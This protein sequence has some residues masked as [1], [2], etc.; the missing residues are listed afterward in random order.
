MDFS[1]EINLFEMKKIITSA[2]VILATATGFSQEV[3]WGVKIGLNN[4]NMRIIRETNEKN[5]DVD[6]KTNS[7][8]SFYVGGL[9]EVPIAE[10]FY[11]QMELQYVINGGKLSDNNQEELDALIDSFRFH[12]LNI[13]ILAKYEIIEGFKL[14]GGGYLGFNL[15]GQVKE[16]RND[17]WINIKEASEGE[18]KPNVVNVGLL[19]GAEYNFRNG[20]FIDA[21]YN[22][23]LT[24]TVNYSEREHV[25]GQIYY[26]N[27]KL[28]NRFLQ[29]GI[30][31]KF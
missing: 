15:L 9:V 22:Y 16:D 23:E 4:S 7:K 6:I 10:K 29:I 26:V 18:T 21:R 17:P 27:E 12:Q 13:P 5:E 24:N 20:F 14:N 3:K 11:G 19:I 1:G 30:G 31:Y 25:L 8:T 2:L 28:K